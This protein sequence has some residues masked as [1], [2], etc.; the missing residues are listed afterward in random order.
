MSSPKKRSTAT[1][2]PPPS[3]GHRRLGVRAVPDLRTSGATT[4]PLGGLTLAA[5]TPVAGPHDQEFVP[6][7]A[8]AGPIETRLSDERELRGIDRSR[9]IDAVAGRL[10]SASPRP[11]PLCQTTR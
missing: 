8:I 1:I 3:E 7:N 2:E 10:L 11:P 5:L 9:R 4:L 6:A